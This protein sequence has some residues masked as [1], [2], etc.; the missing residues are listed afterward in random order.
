MDVLFDALRAVGL[1]LAAVIAVFVTPLIFMLVF[2][3]VSGF[4]DRLPHGD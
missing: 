2:S 1:I 3:L 4:D